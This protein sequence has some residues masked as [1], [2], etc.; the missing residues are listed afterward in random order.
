MLN[1]PSASNDLTDRTH[2]ET[3][4][5]YFPI[6]AKSSKDQWTI[7]FHFEMAGHHFPTAEKKNEF[8]IRGEETHLLKF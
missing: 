7:L 3:D 5:V 2:S 4:I 6:L 8:G 1:T